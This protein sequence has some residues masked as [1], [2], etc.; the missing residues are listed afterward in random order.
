M[1]IIKLSHLYSFSNSG[2]FLKCPH[3]WRISVSIRLNQVKRAEKGHKRRWSQFSSANLIFR[4]HQYDEDDDEDFASPSFHGLCPFSPA[5]LLFHVAV[6]ITKSNILLCQHC[7]PSPPASDFL[8]SDGPRHGV[9][10]RPRSDT[11]AHVQ[12]SS[13]FIVRGTAELCHAPRSSKRWSLTCTATG[14]E[15]QSRR[16]SV[17]NYVL[18]TQI[19]LV[20][21]VRTVCS[22]PDSPIYTLC[23]TNQCVCIHMH[24]R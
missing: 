5:G 19:R 24:V 7:H 22:D 12:K 20:L 16:A 14:T 2:L 4:T 13:G 18:Q 6:F 9:M 8:V 1:H 11:K 21:H 10:T 15:T 17:H 3:C 23:Q